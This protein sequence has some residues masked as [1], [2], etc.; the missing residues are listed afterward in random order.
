MLVTQYEADR[1]SKDVSWQRIGVS[2]V[3]RSI[4]VRYL[5]IEFW[6]IKD[7]YQRKQQ[8]WHYLLMSGLRRAAYAAVL[9]HALNSRCA[10]NLSCTP[11]YLRCNTEASCLSQMFCMFYSCWMLL[12]TLLISTWSHVWLV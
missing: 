5:L 6:L 3:M 1:F 2:H 11:V 4:N 8:H 7:I 10:V 12:T 9:Q